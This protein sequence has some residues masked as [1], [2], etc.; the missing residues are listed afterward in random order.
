MTDIM[1]SC[2][3]LNPSNPLNMVVL[4]LADAQYWRLLVTA[5]THRSRT[6]IIDLLGLSVQSGVGA[7]AIV[8]NNRV[9]EKVDEVELLFDR[10]LHRSGSYSI[11]W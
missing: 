4:R 7:D 6:F 5:Q 10:M 3:E 2:D 1:V 8:W 9:D 11:A